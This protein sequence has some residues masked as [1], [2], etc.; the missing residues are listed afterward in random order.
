MVGPD[1]AYRIKAGIEKKSKKKGNY[2]TI[3]EYQ[4]EYYMNVT[5]KKRAEKRKLK[6][7]VNMNSGEERI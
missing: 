7:S 6:Y 3:I 5:K 4:H 2:R 1:S